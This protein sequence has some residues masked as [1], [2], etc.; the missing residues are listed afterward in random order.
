MKRSMN[1]IMSDDL[2]A[3][4]EHELCEARIAWAD[5]EGSGVYD[6]DEITSCPNDAIGNYRIGGL[7]GGPIESLLCVTHRDRWEDNIVEVIEE[8]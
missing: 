5:D 4:I 3:G 6:Q 8:R 2:T 7:P 1:V